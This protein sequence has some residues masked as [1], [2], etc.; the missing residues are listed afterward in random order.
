MYRG[1]KVAELRQWYLYADLCASW[2]KAARFVGSRL[3]DQRDLTAELRPP[4]GPWSFGVDGQGEVYVV[5][6][7][8]GAV[9]QIVSR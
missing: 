1:P 8:A 6:G 4:G 2:I 9:Y 3:V 5:Y 7:G